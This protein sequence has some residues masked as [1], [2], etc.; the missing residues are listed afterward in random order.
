MWPV[1]KQRQLDQ[2]I[3]YYSVS[4]SKKAKEKDKKKTD[5]DSAAATGAP[6]LSRPEKKKEKKEEKEKGL[7]NSAKRS[8]KQTHKHTTTYKQTNKEN[9]LNKRATKKKRKKKMKSGK[10]GT[11]N[12]ES[13]ADA[14][15]LDWFHF[16]WRFFLP[17]F[18]CF[19]NSSLDSI[20]SSI[21]FFFFSLP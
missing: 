4:Q 17:V 8:K 1:N 15:R 16:I 10:I 19:S 2:T 6:V 7:I 9:K 11:M 20:H 12:A 13:A 21:H 14:I 3:R 5:A 18:Q